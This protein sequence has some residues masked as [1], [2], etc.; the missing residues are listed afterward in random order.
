MTFLRKG[1]EGVTPIGDL[2]WD[3]KGKYP[4]LGRGAVTSKCSTK[5]WNC[6]LLCLNFDFFFKE[7]LSNRNKKRPMKSV[8]WLTKILFHWSFFNIKT[9][10]WKNW[11]TFRFILCSFK[12]RGFGLGVTSPLKGKCVKGDMGWQ[13]E[14]GG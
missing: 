5:Y 10:F 4:N 1:R 11:G 8:F 13:R 12:G 14:G 2:G 9:K 6:M 3:D 7:D